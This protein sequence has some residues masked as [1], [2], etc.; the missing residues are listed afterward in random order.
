MSRISLRKLFSFQ[1]QSAK[2]A[3]RSQC[4]LRVEALEQRLA[5]STLHVGSA[6]GEYHTIQSAVTA[7]NAGDTVQVDPG[8][9]TATVSQSG[10]TLFSRRLNIR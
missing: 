3:G 7:A 2:R 4:K 6:P 5:L 9:Y 10:T 8:T 1:K